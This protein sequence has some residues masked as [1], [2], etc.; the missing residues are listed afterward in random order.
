MKIK[1][2]LISAVAL[3][4]SAIAVQAGSLKLY[5]G[6][7]AFFAFE[8]DGPG[9]TAKFYRVV[10]SHAPKDYYKVNGYLFSYKKA[11]E[12]N[13]YIAYKG[14]S[15]SSVFAQKNT[16][17]HQFDTIRKDSMVIVKGNFY[18]NDESTA[19]TG[20]GAYSDRASRALSGART[21]KTITP[22]SKGPGIYFGVKAG[23]AFLLISGLK[24]EKEARFKLMEKNLDDIDTDL[25][26]VKLELRLNL[27]TQTAKLVSIGNDETEVFSIKMPALAKG[28]S[29]T[30]MN[31]AFLIMTKTPGG[32]G[33][34]AI[35]V[36]TAAKK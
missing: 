12:G 9:K 31:A 25:G 3:S 29:L 21:L 34:C 28:V 15:K 30:D 4:L 33:D 26:W 32:V 35:S 18:V 13:P 17:G 24:G 19:G 6:S 8:G 20:I 27:R 16:D 36:E 1:N 11:S 5:Y 22:K 10:T 2:I 23:K 14:A 7:P